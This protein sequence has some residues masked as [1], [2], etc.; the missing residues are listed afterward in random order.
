M[1]GGARRGKQKRGGLCGAIPASTGGHDRLE[2]IEGTVPN[3]LEFPSGCKFHPRCTFATD[4]CTKHE[5]EL[6]DLGEGHL[7]ACWLTDPS[8]PM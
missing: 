1:E 7:S 2:T 6:L 5:P 3:P 8:G 4:H